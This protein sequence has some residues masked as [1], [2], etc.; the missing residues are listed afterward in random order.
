MAR[1]EMLMV[2]C[3]DVADDRARR[4]LADLLEEHLVRV[5]R[6]VFEARMSPAAAHRLAEHAARLL[7]PGDSLRLYAI[8]RLGR[9]HCRSFGPQPLPEEQDFYLL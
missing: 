2:F 3:Y 1:R 4:R 7:G 8:G 6:S 9:R 5:Q